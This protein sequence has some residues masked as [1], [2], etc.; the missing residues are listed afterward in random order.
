MYL[1]R[2]YGEL[3]QKYGSIEILLRKTLHI[4]TGLYLRKLFL[5]SYS[6]PSFLKEKDPADARTHTY[7]HL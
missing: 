4:C 6:S 5:L 3:Y 2:S 1:F 7:L